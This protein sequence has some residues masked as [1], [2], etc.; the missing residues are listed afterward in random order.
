[1]TAAASMLDEGQM[2]RFV[3]LL[4]CHPE[5]GGFVSLRSFFDA[6]DGVFRIEAVPLTE[7]RLA[8]KERAVIA[9]RAAALADQAVVFCPPVATLN[10]VKTAREQDLANGVALS[11]ECD[12]KPAEIRRKL[13]AI[14]G[15]ATV[16]AASGGVWRDEATGTVEDKLHLHWRL[17]QPTRDCTG[18]AKLK[19]ARRCA[20]SLTGADASNVP[21]VHP[22]R[23]PGSNHRKAAPRVCR[24]IAEDAGAEIQ[25]DDALQKLKKALGFESGDRKS[26]G[27]Q[28]SDSREEAPGPGRRNSSDGE[29]RSTETLIAKIVTGR[30][31]HAP[32]VALAF[33]Y[34]LG[35]MSDPQVVLTLRGF[36]DAV[37]ADR[38]DVKDG[39]A[40]L[41][42]WISRY[43]AVPGIVA[44][45]RRK[46]DADGA[47]GSRGA[48]GDDD[49][50][51]GAAPAA[52]DN[53]GDSD[54]G[55]GATAE[56]AS[57]GRSLQ[58][59]TI[60]SDVDIAAAVAK[61]L[62]AAFGEV[63]YADGFFWRFADTR[64]LAVTEQQLRLGI[65][66]YDGVRI[67]PKSQVKLSKNRIDSV[68]HE[69]GTM[70][71]QPDFF[72]NPATGINCASGFIRFAADGS[73]ALEEHAPGHR[74]RHVLPGTYPIE[75]GEDV[76]G[77][78]LLSKLLNGC[79]AEDEEAGAKVELLSEVAGAAALGFGPR[80]KAPKAVILA[81]K[82]AENGKSQVLNLLRGLLPPEAVAALAL[83]KF[84]ED[85]Y[86]VHL[87]GKLLNA[88]D[89]LSSAAAIASDAFKSVVTG[90]PVIGRDVYRSA[91][92]FRPVAQ[93]VFATND[94]PAFRGGMDRGVQRRLLVIPFDRTIPPDERIE[95]IGQRIVE[96]EMNLLLDW[97][98][99][100][101]ARLIKRRYFSEPSSC[102]QA[103]RE[104]ILGAD[105]VLAWLEEGVTI[106]LGEYAPEVTVAEAF[107]HFFAWATGEGYA[108][109]TLPRI[110]NFSQRVLAADKGIT[111]GRSGNRRY[112]VGLRLPAAGGAQHFGLGRW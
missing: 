73:P 89:E 1:M 111:R 38:R 16:V 67:N 68:I 92:T 34:L 48:G 77:R 14:L 59:L 60:G 94:L 10:N 64:W 58:P 2:C 100:G 22:I 53:G 84:G 75:I 81:G 44:S 42:R 24:I 70:L 105:P 87:A 82:T 19:L 110:N 78:S 54:P 30:E 104:W 66:R 45:A 4:F 39:V 12:A 101:A 13:E 41:G 11:V 109:A 18:H 20:V 35:G 74:C 79:F 5:I 95:H 85:R 102:K 32:L 37:P 99:G 49:S 23:W 27:Q 40:A 25:L 88:S 55:V 56:A 91:V 108:E 46:I 31:L 62:K 6:S 97:A 106:V 17:A 107:K 61:D 8:L 7:D 28:H 43:S 86:V 36:L 98:V 50:R 103:L 96:E 76:A 29:E 57:G 69:L 65:H 71:A 26:A 72:A 63:P 15:P 112:F 83:G 90:E 93:H 9:A 51:S 80:L 52:D 21:V 3:D 33:R 47:G